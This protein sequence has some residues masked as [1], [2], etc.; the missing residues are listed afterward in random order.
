MTEGDRLYFTRFFIGYLSSSLL[1]SA[2]AAS[3]SP[4]VGLQVVTSTRHARLC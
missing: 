2:S 3:F 4:S 1:T